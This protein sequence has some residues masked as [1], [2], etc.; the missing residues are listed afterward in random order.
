MQQKSSSQAEDPL[1]QEPP[2]NTIPLQE[3]SFLLKT[4]LCQRYFELHA[5]KEALMNFQLH[6]KMLSFPLAPLSSLF[7]LSDRGC[8]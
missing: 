4:T 3:H 7:H 1:F 8:H 6:F 5:C 2:L